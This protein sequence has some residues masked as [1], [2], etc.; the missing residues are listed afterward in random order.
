MSICMSSLAT[1]TSRA[2]APH[3]MSILSTHSTRCIYF[4]DPDDIVPP[5]AP[6][7][8]VPLVPRGRNNSVSQPEAPPVILEPPVSTNPLLCRPTLP[9]SEINII[10][11][12]SSRVNVLPVVGRADTLTNER[13]AAIKMAVRRDLAGAGIGFGIFDLNNHAQYPD[14][15]EGADASSGPITDEANP[16]GS[17]VNGSASSSSTSSP[18]TSTTTP[19][20]RLPYALIAPDCY[21][22]SD[23]VNRTTP[24]RHELV[25]QY[26]PSPHSPA[27]SHALSKLVR[28]KF[29]R[30][31]RWGFL[32]VLDHAHSDFLPLRTAIFHHMEVGQVFTR[33]CVALG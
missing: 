24:S 8:P 26:T 11:G 17:A 13:L 30:S 28:K 2:S 33:M 10:R 14:V 16:Y 3:S 15:N 1:S 32:D 12:L 6:T 19:L 7:P 29:I 22:H 27:S 25:Q 21:S 18:T 31:Y 9:P 4:L 23:G 20:L 5:S